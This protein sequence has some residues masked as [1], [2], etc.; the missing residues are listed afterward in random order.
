MYIFN[1][2]KKFNLPEFYEISLNEI[3]YNNEFDLAFQLDSK[4]RKI[5]LFVSKELLIISTDVS[6][7]SLKE[8]E[9]SE[10]DYDNASLAEL[11]DLLKIYEDESDYITCAKIRDIIN[12]KYNATDAN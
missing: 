10:I 5:K 8:L 6:Q 7:K 2:L 12:T 1:M 11:K 3:Y 9:S 4:S